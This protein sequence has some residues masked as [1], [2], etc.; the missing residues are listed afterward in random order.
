MTGDRAA[1]GAVDRR[2]VLVWAGALATA[3]GAAH[4]FDISLT[5]AKAEA[6]PGYGTDPAMTDPS[7]PWLRPL[8]PSQRAAV[9]HV[10][11]FILPR[12]GEAPSAGEVGIPDLIDEW[13]SA[14]YPEQLKDRTLI[15]DGLG[16]LDFQARRLGDAPLISPR[17]A[18][19]YSNGCWRRLPI[20]C[21]R[22]RPPAS[23]PGCGGW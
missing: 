14:P 7:V 1:E 8:T 6:A 23:T 11:D 20:R 22:C 18:R 17:P 15:L 13:V 2:A 5:G 3:I 10:A 16:H 21:A 9:R 12:E 19:T 4:H